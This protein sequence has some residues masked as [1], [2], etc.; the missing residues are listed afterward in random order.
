MAEEKK[1]GTK[2]ADNVVGSPNGLGK[3][4]GL[5]A[6][7]VSTKPTQLREASLEFPY[8]FLSLG[9]LI[10]VGLCY[11]RGTNK[12]IGTHNKGVHCVSGL[13]HLGCPQIP[14]KRLTFSGLNGNYH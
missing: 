12:I 8:H 1:K 11:I 6:R 13:S 10:L 4:G 14:R 7:I 2:N 9:S 5:P 3:V